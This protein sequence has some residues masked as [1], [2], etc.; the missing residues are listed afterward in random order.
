MSSKWSASASSAFGSRSSSSGGKS[1]Q[2]R[3]A[4]AAFFLHQQREM[5][6][7]RQA[8]AKETKRL[9]EAMNFASMDTYPS[10]GGAMPRVQV[11]KPVMSFSKTVAAMAAKVKAEEE[12]AAAAAEA[13]A[14]EYRAM[15]PELST[16]RLRATYRLPEVE[17]EDMEEYDEDD[18]DDYETAPPEEE[19]ESEGEFNADLG[20][21]RRRGDRGIW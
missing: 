18:M 11:E 3:A 4:E 15:N 1:E 21:T 17:Y 12:A 14:A 13:A 20:D 10:L 2:K 7:K 5:Q 6:Q 16:T 19:E 9:E 8:E